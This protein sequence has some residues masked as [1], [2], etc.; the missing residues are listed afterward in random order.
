MPAVLVRG[1]CVTQNS[2]WSRFRESF[3]SIFLYEGMD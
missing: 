1:L 3:A 2:P